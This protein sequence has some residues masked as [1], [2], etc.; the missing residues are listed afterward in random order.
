MEYYLELAKTD[1]K[2][3]KILMKF[4]LK[5]ILQNPSLTY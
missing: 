3:Q 4:N 5:E 1:Q 2:F